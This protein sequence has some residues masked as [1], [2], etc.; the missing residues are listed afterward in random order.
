MWYTYKKDVHYIIPQLV[1]LVINFVLNNAINLF[2]LFNWKFLGSA[3][4]YTLRIDYKYLFNPKLLMSKK[5]SKQNNKMLLESFLL[6]MVYLC[7]AIQPV[8]CYLDCYKI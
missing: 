2:I 8:V 5:N 6:F 1:A 7:D 4:Q 3:A